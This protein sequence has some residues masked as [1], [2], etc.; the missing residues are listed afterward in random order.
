MMRKPITLFLA[1]AALAVGVYFLVFKKDSPVKGPKEQPLN[2]SANS[3]PFNQSFDQL[4]T[5]YMEV[6]DALV[7]ADTVK[8][9]LAANSLAQAADSLKTEEITGDST[10]ALKATAKDF[11]LTINGS[12]KGILGETDIDNK[13]KDFELV[14][15]ALYNLVRTVKYSGKKLFYQYC[16]MAFNDKGAYWMSTEKEIRNPYFGNKMLTCGEVKD[17]VDYS[18]R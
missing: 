17:S 7:A 9:N 15:D 4:L 6:K 18:K 5:A 3:Q 11:A 14:T 1:I 10:G 13:R 8:V 2:I 16:P 12:A